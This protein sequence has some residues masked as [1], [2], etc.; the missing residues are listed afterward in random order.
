MRRFLSLFFSFGLFG[1]CASSD[2]DDSGGTAPADPRRAVITNIAAL[3]DDIYNANWVGVT[4]G[5]ANKTTTCPAGGS[6]VI[7]G[8]YACPTVNGTQVVNM[9][10]T[11]D[12]TDCAIIRNSLT[13]KMSGKMTH[14]G[15]SSS[16]SQTINYQSIGPMTIVGTGD[17]YVPFNE[18]CEFA[19]TSRSS[20]ASTTATV[21][22]TLC[23]E[24]LP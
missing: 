18:S 22:G 1:G 14:A 10:F 24:S 4:C 6:V 9:N 7:S 23:G 15:S 13:L 11:Y 3:G 2:S 16:A 8:E 19:V 17:P 20:S 5:I 21:N 12:M